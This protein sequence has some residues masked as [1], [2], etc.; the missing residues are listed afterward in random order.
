MS[1][2]SIQ[3]LGQL[4][5][6]SQHIVCFTGA[7]I[8]TESGIPDF[9]S[10]GTGLWTKMKPIQFQDFMAS[11]EA[12]QDSWHRKFSG[13]RTMENATPNPGH[14]ALARL[15]E[16]GRCHAII[17]QNVDN[18]H[19]NSGVPDEK[20]IELHGNA[21]YATC[22][23]CHTRYELSDLESEFKS[24]QRVAPCSR[25]GG[26]IKTATI[27]FGQS[28]P[29]AEMRR[30]QAATQACDLMI[31]LGS[32]LSVYPAAGF[33]EYAQRAGAKLAIVNREETP[34]D[35]VADVVVREQIGPTMSLVVGL[36]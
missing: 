8:S 9:R 15:V 14:H 36:N 20:V 12:R 30:A 10:P 27:S 23:A 6:E 33:P 4:I 3:H 24:S 26:I 18:L 21:C 11:E 17:T 28:M 31:V 25:C 22:L 34:L 32:S 16:D 35:D 19:Q 29:E 7:G 1:E 13:D 5:D 2:E